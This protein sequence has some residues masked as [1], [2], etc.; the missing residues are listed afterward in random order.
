MNLERTVTSA[1]NPSDYINCLAYK[2]DAEDKIDHVFSTAPRFPSMYIEIPENS[3][4]P[5]EFDEYIIRNIKILI[6]TGRVLDARLLLS[7]F[8][9]GISSKLDNWRRVLSIPKAKPEKVATGVDIK[10]NSSWLINNSEKFKGKWVALKN[11]ILLGGHESRIELHRKLTL[12]NKLKGA[13][14]FKIG[15]G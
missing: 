4:L 15:K 2:D 1:T 3:S 5:F 6:E 9:F 13:A 10:Q 7:S 8:P 14:F 12:A 11:G